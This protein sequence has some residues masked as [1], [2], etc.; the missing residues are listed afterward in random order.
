MSL[1]DL[2]DNLS[3]T[4]V[5]GHDEREEDRA[6]GLKEWLTRVFEEELGTSEILTHG[7]RLN[8]A[9]KKLMVIQILSKSMIHTVNKKCRDLFWS[10]R[11]PTM[12]QT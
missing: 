7:F 5:V 12:Q 4:F 3:N 8:L 11:R 9:I 1:E 10:E 6:A 2:L